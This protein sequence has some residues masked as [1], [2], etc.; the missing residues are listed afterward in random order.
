M[1]TPITRAGITRSA[2]RGIFNTRKR[3]PQKFPRRLGIIPTTSEIVSIGVKPAAKS[4]GSRRRGR[5]KQVCVFWI[6][7]IRLG[8]ESETFIGTH[9]QI[10]R[11]AK[12]GHFAFHTEKNF[13]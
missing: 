12:R 1:R 5:K 4:A 7:K 8:K 9:P 13:L 3:P 2:I 11:P 6:L 10:L